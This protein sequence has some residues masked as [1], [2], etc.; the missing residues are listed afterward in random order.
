MGTAHV[1]SYC[2]CRKD[3]CQVK[4]SKKAAAGRAVF[5]TIVQVAYRPTLKITAGLFRFHAVY[6]HRPDIDMQRKG[7]RYEE[8]PIFSSFFSGR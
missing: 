5:D 8:I 4:F 6:W 1:T 2:I 3:N 7:V